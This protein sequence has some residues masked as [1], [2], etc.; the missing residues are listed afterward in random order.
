MMA[1]IN[2]AQSLDTEKIKEVMDKGIT[3]VSPN[4]KAKTVP[5]PDHGNNRACDL[6]IAWNVKTITGGI[7][8]K[9]DYVTLEE[10]YEYNKKF[11]GW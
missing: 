5:R 1:G 6:V 9:I 4:G 7:P 8:K 3:F 10:A 2:K 11:R